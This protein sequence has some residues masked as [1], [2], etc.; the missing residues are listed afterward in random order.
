VGG[1]SSRTAGKGTSGSGEPGGGV[2]KKMEVNS[3]KVGKQLGGL[4]KKCDTV[5]ALRGGAKTLQ[6]VRKKAGG[7]QGAG[8]GG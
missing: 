2:E 5:K 4:R 8:R 3:F 6:N 1:G 7:N